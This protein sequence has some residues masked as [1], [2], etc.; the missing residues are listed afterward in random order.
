MR[1]RLAA[2][3]LFALVALR[4]RMIRDATTRRRVVSLALVPPVF[5][6]LA[7]AGG[8]AIPEE[9]RFSISL[10]LPTVAVATVLVAVIAPLVAGGGNEL[11][12]RDQLVAFPVTARTVYLGSLLLAPLNAAWLLQLTVLLTVTSVAVGAAPGLALSLLS[13][14]LFTVLATVVGQS[15]A[16]AVAG[17]RATRRGRLG[18]RLT[19]A[20]LLAVAAAIVAAGLTTAVLDSGPTRLV[21]NLVFDGANLVW[22][23]WW[24]ATLLLVAGIVLAAQ[25]GIAAVRWGQRRPGWSSGASGSVASGRAAVRSNVDPGAPSPVHTELT[26]VQRASVWRAPALR[27]GI[28]V[29]AVLARGRRGRGR[30][31]VADPE[32]AAHI[33]RSGGRAAVRRQRVR[34]RR[35]RC[36]LAGQPAGLGRARCSGRRPRWWPRRAWWRAC[37]LCSV[38]RS[39]RPRRARR[40]R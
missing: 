1:T 35:R 13:M 8:L 22:S 11:Y 30:A 29:L 26:A 37:W 40:A 17:L 33:D 31:R 12:P 7:V 10:L 6:T 38:V 19:L 3:P 25:L 27:R 39:R 5:M 36:D 23:S 15:V 9:R 28:L 34:A 32:P 4:W 18:T 24:W 2:A 14:L 16:W 21:V 20:A